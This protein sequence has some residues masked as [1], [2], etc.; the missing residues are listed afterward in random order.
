MSQTRYQAPIRRSQCLLVTPL[1]RLPPV[2]ESDQVVRQYIQEAKEGTHLLAAA[3]DFHVGGTQRETQVVRFL[4]VFGEAVRVEA[5]PLNVKRM[6]FP[7]KDVS[8]DVIAEDTVRLVFVE[9]RGSAVYL[10][11][12]ARTRR[13]TRDAT[14]AADHVNKSPSKAALGQKAAT[15]SF[16]VFYSLFSMVSSNGTKREE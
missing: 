16:C 2:A 4:K 15:L 10:H 12:F 3:S 9:G 14:N 7:W 13:F 5:R 1:P 6:V 8:G 11:Y